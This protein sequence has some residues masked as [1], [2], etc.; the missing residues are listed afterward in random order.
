VPCHKCQKH[1]TFESGIICANYGHPRGTFQPCRRAY[2]AGCFSAHKLD[3]FETAVPRDFNGASLA[4]VEDELRFRQARPG[5]H[6]CC[7]FQCPNCQSQNIRGCDID[8]EDVEDMAF[9]SLC[10]R[11]TLDAFWARSSKTVSTHVSN[12]RRVAAFAEMLGILDP[13]P[14][15][16]PYPLGHHL[17]ML[18]AIFLL[19]RSNDPGTGPS[20]RVKHGTARKVRSLF[21][22]LWEASPLSGSDIV[23]SS[24]GTKQNYVATCNPAEG[25]WY[26]KFS[27]GCSVRIGDVTKQDRAFTIQILLKLLS[28]YEAEFNDLGYDMPLESMY[29]CMFLL[30]TCLGGMRGYEAVWTDLAALRYDLEFCEHAEDYSGISWPIVGRF[31]AHGGVAGCYMIPIAGTTNSGIRFFRWTQRFVIR[32]SREGITEGSRW[33]S[34]ESFGISR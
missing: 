27:Q 31:K 23:L 33:N 30:L 8:D 6:L 28:M 19:M 20:G 14:P 17:G 2:C 22:I 18:Q 12:A 25:N 5:D 21:T 24:G 16:G 29:S 4:E 34:R 7:P 3:T 11:A 15:L 1:V 13:M 9:E 32:L 10:T 26:S